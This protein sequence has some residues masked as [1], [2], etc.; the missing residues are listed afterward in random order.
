VIQGT[1]PLDIAALQANPSQLRI[2][3]ADITNS[4]AKWFT[5]NTGD[6]LNIMKAACSTE[7][8]SSRP[9]SIQG[10][11]YRDGYLLEPIPLL[12]ALEENY[13]DILVLLNKPMSMRDAPVATWLQEGIINPWNKKAFGAGLVQLCDN[14]W[15]TYNQA[16][17][18]IH[19]GIYK[20]CHGREI[21]I[22]AIAPDL[23][24][25]M[26]EMSAKR[27]FQAA[28][29]SWKNTFRALG[30]KE[31]GRGPFLKVL[32]DAGLKRSILREL[33]R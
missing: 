22:A 14:S 15:K 26:F 16:L 1:K 13:T 21:R 27:L 31:S 32:S 24:I 11:L 19:S 6:V 12:S 4:R 18:I 23:G 10:S 8:P 29:S 20:N 7:I 28:C 33:S 25:G 17:D 30:A 3:T 2:L 9:V 5:A